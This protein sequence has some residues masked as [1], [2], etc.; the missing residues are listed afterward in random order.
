MK[1]N[2]IKAVYLKRYF[3]DMVGK[4]TQQE[5]QYGKCLCL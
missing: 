5:F 1:L 3:S 4:E 2:R